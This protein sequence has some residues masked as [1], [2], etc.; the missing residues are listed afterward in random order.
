VSGGGH[1][2]PRSAATRVVQAIALATLFGLLYFATRVIPASESRATAV[3]AVGFLLLAGT[4]MSEL[5]EIIGLPHLSGYLVAGIVAGPHVLRLIDHHTVEQLTNVNSLA[6]ALIALEGGAE[7]RLSA[8]REGMRGLVWAMVMQ[9]VPIMLIVGG[10]FILAKPLMPFLATLP[11]SAVLGAGLLWGVVAMTRSPSAALGILSQTRANGPV[12]RFTLNFVMCSDIVVVVLMA[13]GIMAAR[14]LCDPAGSF[15]F[16]EFERLGHEILGSVALGTTLGVILILY[17]RFIGKQLVLVYL[18]LGFGMSEVLNYLGFEKLLTFMVAGFVVQNLSKQG[19]K[20]LP[21]IAQMGSIVYVIFFAT[22][23]AHLN[24]PLMK[25]LWKVALLFFVARALITIAAAKIAAYAAKDSAILK[26][27]SWSGLISQA[28]VALGVA[29]TIAVQFPA[30]GAQFRDIAIAC[31]GLNE[32]FGPV[33][34]KFA[35]DRS[36]ETST[37]PR[38]SLSSLDDEAKPAH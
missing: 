18:A 9:T 1:K 23:G 32:L 3:A 10:I 8:L 30:F 25:E 12:A 11:T 17:L 38:A 28:G 6:L 36:G 13:A 5:F 14:P 15:S 22:A 20:L 16:K 29:S 21:S 33:M 35:L 4:L 2:A 19:E 31:I 7:L 37:A 26:T 24:V 27:Y 34:F